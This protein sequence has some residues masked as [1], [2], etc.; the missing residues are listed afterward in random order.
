[1]KRR[2]LLVAGLAA[3]AILHAPSSWAQSGGQP[4]W[5]A[6]TVRFICPFAPGGG[7]DTVSRLMCDQL[8]RLLGQQFVVENKGGA[9]GN[10]GTAELA[11]A[12][13]DG[14]TLGVI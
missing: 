1:M 9:G 7:T 6:K 4:A 2:S 13:P 11:R 14:Y 3:P 10:I 12:A 5:P 8:T